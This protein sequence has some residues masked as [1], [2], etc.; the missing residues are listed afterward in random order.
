MK[1][2]VSIVVWSL[3]SLVAATAFA[4][5]ALYRGEPISAAW[6]LL[7]ALCSYAVGYRFYS[8]ISAERVFA[9]DDATPTPANVHNDGHDFVPTN[10]WVV[11]GHHFAAIAGA[12]PLVGPILAAQFGYLPGTIWI[13]VGAVLAGATHD[14]VVLA[15]SMRRGGKSLGQMARD[16]VGPLTGWLALVSMLMILV[17]LIAVLAMVVVKALAESPWGTVTIGCT[18]VIA[19]IMGVWMRIIR[20][21]RVLEASLIGVALLFAA[22]WLG[23]F[24]NGSPTLAPMFTFSEK[25]IA[26]GIIVYGFAAAVLP[27]WVLLAPRDYLSA[28]VKIGTIGL[29]AIGIFVVLPRIAMPALTSETP[30]FAHG[31][32]LGDGRGPVFPGT[33]FPFAFITIACGA[34]S[35]F[36]ALISSGTTPKLIAKESEAR[37]IGYGSMLM[38]SFVAIMALIAACALS[39]GLY[40]VLN[41]PRAM[42]GADAV[43]AAHVVSSW[44]FVIRPE[45]ITH[46]A[47]S[48]EEKSIIARTGGAPT[49]A[50]GMAQIFAS[51]TKGW[52]GEHAPA[53]WYHFA[54]MF[55]ALFIL[56]TV[57]AGTRVGRLIFKT[58]WGSFTSRLAATT[59]RLDCGAA[60]S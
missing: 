21:G 52:A 32:I 37:F 29:L 5:L 15:A 42:L 55:E 18:I 50:V 6:I 30:A 43:S 17:I 44:G 53:F 4:V 56:T 35:G 33:M 36:H 22:L 3:I 34:I 9:L 41:S 47:A 38:E 46:L 13:I 60:A 11:F 12:G 20:P 1:R 24:V 58:S 48:L 16:E 2:L 39:P 10:K 51:F 59:T 40:F 7:A 45:D 25:Q 49:L 19:I 31:G 54:I 27:V 28:F 8:K 23:R 26:Y 14:F 57:D